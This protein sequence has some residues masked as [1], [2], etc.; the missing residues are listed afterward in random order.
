ME[1]KKKEKKVLKK[2]YWAFIIYP[3]EDFLKNK[4]SLYDGSDGYGTAP[5]NFLDV[6]KELCIPCC[7]SPLHDCDVNADG[8]FKKPHY[9]VILTF[10]GPTTFENVVELIKPFNSPI[11][12]PLSSLKG[13]YR[14]LTHMDNPDKYQYDSKDILHFSNFDILSFSDLKKGEIFKIKKELTSLINDKKI[15]EYIDLLFYCFENLSDE[16][17]EVVASNTYFFT[18]VL[19]SARFKAKANLLDKI[20]DDDIIILNKKNGE[21]LEKEF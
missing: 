8:V 6:L 13:Y 18:S 3:T 14:Y 15:Y 5:N 7:V 12:Q 17:S 10:D 21:I 4:K 2:R 16:Y 19:K 20:N 11:P 1:I 9:H